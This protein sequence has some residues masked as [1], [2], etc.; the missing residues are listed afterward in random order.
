MDLF[1][2]KWLQ[3][4]ATT[5]IASIVLHHATVSVPSNTSIPSS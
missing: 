4:P 1:A 5:D 2:G 3:A